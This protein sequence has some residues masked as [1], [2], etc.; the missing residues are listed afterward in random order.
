M[1]K[2]R[3]RTDKE[4]LRRLAYYTAKHPADFSEAELKEFEALKQKY[5]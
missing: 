3:K 4:N 2:Q 1:A 5:G